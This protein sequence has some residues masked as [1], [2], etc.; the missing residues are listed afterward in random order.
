MKNFFNLVGHIV[1]NAESKLHLEACEMRDIW[2]EYKEDMI[3]YFG[4]T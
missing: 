3:T 1:S 4:E 2:K